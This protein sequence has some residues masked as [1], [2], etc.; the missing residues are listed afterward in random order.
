MKRVL[1]AG[2]ALTMLARYSLANETSEAL[3]AMSEDKR[4]EAWTTILRQHDEKCDAVVRTIFHGADRPDTTAW[5]VGCR[6]QGT[7]FVSVQI[8]RAGK[9]SYYI[10][11]CADLKILS[12]AIGLGSDAPRDPTMCWGLQ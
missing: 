1:A 9:P 12:K 3:M 5:S 2:L 10:F 4:H 6:D 7:Y 8:G 11:P